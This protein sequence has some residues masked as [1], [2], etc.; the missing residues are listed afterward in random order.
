V[1]CGLRISDWRL[2]FAKEIE[3]RQKFKDEELACC[4]MKVVIFR[5]IALAIVSLF[6]DGCG[7][8]SNP[9][10]ALLTDHNQPPDTDITSSPHYNFSSFA[11][12]V[13]K[14]KV[15]GGLADL[16]HYTGEHALALLVPEHFDPADPDYTPAPYMQL[17][18]VLSA[19]TNVRIERLI[20]D[21]GIGSDLM[22]QATLL[23]GT[24]AQHTIYLD[25]LF[26]AKNLFLW[27][28]S[29]ISTNWDVNPDM[30]EKVDLNSTRQP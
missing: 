2:P 4:F 13:W 30:L 5:I 11:G 28:G 1:S 26:L 20:Q 15:K 9:D 27:P 25:D 21:N 7:Q 29:S 14:T 19:G 17:I 8:S 16:K 22:V 3:T 23:D 6:L 24:N 10:V 12:T 18:T